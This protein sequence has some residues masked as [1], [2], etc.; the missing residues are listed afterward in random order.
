MTLAF[1]LFKYFPFGGLE[2]LFFQIASETVKRGHQI[3]VFTM[4]WD[5]P[6]PFPITILSPRGFSNHSRAL[7]FSR[8][9]KEHLH[10][11][12]A[13]IGFNKMPGLDVYFAAD[14]CFK[15]QAFEQHSWFYRLGSRCRTYVAL[16][17]SVFS[18]IVP[19]QIL[20][21]VESERSRFIQ[22]YQTPA[23]RFHLLPPG[24]VRDWKTPPDPLQARIA[25]RN[26]LN[27]PVHSTILLSVGSD[28]KRKGLDRSIR[29]LAALPPNQR[30]QTFLVVLGQGKAN[31]YFKLA[32]H[33][34]VADH[35]RLL[36]PRDDVRPFFSGADL[37]LHP[38]RSEAAGM[39]LIEA[40]CCALP[41][42]ASDH[43]GYA[44][45]VEKASAGR[46]IPSPFDQQ[47]F[48][49]TL[50]ELLA[51]PAHKQWGMNGL[52]YVQQSGVFELPEKTAAL[53]ETL[54]SGA[55]SF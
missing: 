30:K 15:A 39:V 34:G 7:N 16:E 20:L 13:V 38:A 11:F 46:L 51:D 44:P 14:P 23:N 35:L 3:E 8:Q 18:P 52:Q 48:N 19:T 17:E 31:P 10:R 9:V 43:C 42:I 4:H 49:H 45:H 29:A 50:A 47:H 6:K 26:E 55:T 37:L 54:I 2:R 41:V 12:D 36:G 22:H 40:M 24:V 1:C 25:I 53:I 28:F 33:L 21:M 27:L 32:T 5:G